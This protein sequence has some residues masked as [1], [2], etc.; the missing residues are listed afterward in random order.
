MGAAASVLKTM[1]AITNHPSGI[2]DSILVRDA[3]SGSP[4]A[5]AELVVRYRSASLKMATA[6]LR[7][8]E[9]AEDEVQ[10]ALCKAFQHLDK[11]QQEAQFSTWLTRIVLNQ[12]FMRLRQLRR[13]PIACLDAD[14]IKD[15]REFPFV[16]PDSRETPEEKVGREQMIDLVRQE[17]RRIPP[18][19]RTAIVLRDIEQLPMPSVA[20]KLGVKV[21]AAKS[22]LQR[23]RTELKERLKQHYPASK[24]VLTTR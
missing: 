16:I 24:E 18:V 9:E 8:R 21:P 17:L 14:G 3:Q 22:R 19:L 23:G 2:E 15:P 5:F 11:F 4:S 13:H 12:C 7:N 10:N 6:I 1:K 20:E